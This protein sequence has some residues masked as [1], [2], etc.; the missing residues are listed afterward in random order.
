MENILSDNILK[1]E[2]LLHIPAYSWAFSKQNILK[3][4]RYFRNWNECVN[5]VWK[6]IG[7][8]FTVLMLWLLFSLIAPVFMIPP[9]VVPLSSYSLNISWEKPADNVTRGKVVGYDINMISEQSLQ[10]SIPVVFSQ[11]L[12]FLTSILSE[13]A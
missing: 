4:T 10:Q 6:Y 3:G 1:S 11:V 7:T 9:S 2:Y 12:L 5:S 13:L 8:A